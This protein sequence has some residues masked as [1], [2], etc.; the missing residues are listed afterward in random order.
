MAYFKKRKNKWLVQIKKKGYPRQY[1][2]F[3]DKAT[4]RRWAREIESQMDKNI[5]ED[6]SSSLGTS[7]KDLLIKYKEE[8]TS[9]KK[10]WREENS[11]INFLINH[12][13]ALQS[14]MRLK[15]A[16]IYKLKAE[17][18][19]SRKVGTVNKY[20]HIL[21]HTWTTAKK[22]WSISLP[23]Q[24][25]FDLVS[26]DK[27]LDVR[28]RVLTHDE[29]KKLLKASESSNLP[30][31]KDL[32]IFSYLTGVRQGELLK[33][34][35]RD[36][37]FNKNVCVLR[38]TKNSEDRIIPLSDKCIAILK[39]YPFGDTVFNIVGRRLR[40]HFLIACRKANIENFRWHDLRAC[41]ATNALMSGMSIAQV[42]TITGHKDWSQLKRYTR[43]KAEDL[44]T[45]V[46]KIVSIK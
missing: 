15:S 8:V 11:K 27:D 29:Y 4:A 31:L 24:N 13:I 14:V 1:K 17:L 36:I 41:F 22:V 37:D 16:H 30:M 23:H 25:P 10:G 38:D 20:L 18:S 42:S 44:V 9:K 40:K 7:L 43:I 45:H 32:I 19:I 26:L 35:R 5:F 12:K 2:T 39:K 34:K 3:F 46:N 33:I 6:Y 28:D 21:S